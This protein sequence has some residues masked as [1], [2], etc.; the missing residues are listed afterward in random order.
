M[1]VIRDISIDDAA[2]R[3][4]SKLGGPM[5]EELSNPPTMTSK[6]PP[7]E[8][9]EAFI[10]DKSIDKTV[11]QQLR[12]VVGRVQQRVLAHGSCLDP[13]AICLAR[14]RVA[15]SNLTMF[16]G[17]PLEEIEAFI[18]DN[19]IDDTAAQQLRSVDRPIQQSVLDRGRCLNPSAVCL[20]RIR[21]AQVN[22][23]IQ[24]N[25]IEETTSQQLR[26][27]CGPIQ[28]SVLDGGN[29]E[30]R[31]AAGPVK[32][33]TKFAI[34]MDLFPVFMDVLLDALVVR[35]MLKGY[36]ILFATIILST[37]VY[38]TTLEVAI[39]R[40]KKLPADLKSAL[41]TGVYSDR[42]LQILDAEK[43]IEAFVSLV[44]TIYAMPLN[45]KATADLMTTGFSVLLS[46][47]G[48]AKY[49]HQY[50]DLGEGGLPCTSEGDG[51]GTS[52]S[53]SC[54]SE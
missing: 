42:V 22:A 23:F 19:S 2:W 33:L 18:W 16:E 51:D 50:Y 34:F 25:H 29:C 28:Q 15:Y 17:P 36:H 46:I 12:G 1:T 41:K 4:L 53:S 43:S 6:R 20:A 52:S 27:A 32:P 39:G 26:W 10:C 35:R 14:I 9:V 49:H 47:Y 54:T 5:H 44:V 21:D 40:A 37:T 11:A 7:E 13:S 8:E 24:E 38:S 3:Q 48:I 31:G 45:A 30:L